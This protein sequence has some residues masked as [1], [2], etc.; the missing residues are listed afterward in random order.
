MLLIEFE[1]I[2]SKWKWPSWSG[3]IDEIIFFIKDNSCV[4]YS[5]DPRHRLSVQFYSAIHCGQNI[6]IK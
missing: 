1:K 3:P 2:A 5:L 4:Q 6:Y